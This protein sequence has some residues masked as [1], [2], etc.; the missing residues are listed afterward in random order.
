[1]PETAQRPKRLPDNMA[2]QL[3]A[4]REGRATAVESG[5]EEKKARIIAAAEKLIA[6]ANLEPRLQVEAEQT[7]WGDV[8]DLW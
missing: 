7:F 5:D 2:G 4:L 1:M 6:K 3:V 8:A